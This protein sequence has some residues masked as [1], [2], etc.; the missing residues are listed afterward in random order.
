MLDAWGLQALAASGVAISGGSFLLLLAL[1][2]SVVGLKG[3][4]KRLVDDQGIVRRACIPKELLESSK[5]QAREC[6]DKKS[7]QTEKNVTQLEAALREAAGAIQR[8]DKEMKKMI[9]RIQELET[10]QG[11]SLKIADTSV[12]SAEKS[13]ERDPRLLKT[14]QMELSTEQDY[15]E[16]MGDRQKS[17]L[18]GAS[19][20][21]SV[22]LST[23]QIHHNREHSIKSVSQSNTPMGV[24]PPHTTAQKDK[25]EIAMSPL[26]SGSN[27]ADTSPVPGPASAAVSLR[28]SATHSPGECPD[29]GAA[30]PNYPEGARA[31][32][33][34]A[35]R[36]AR[37]GTDSYTSA[38]DGSIMF[39]GGPRTSGGSHGN[40]G[41]DTIAQDDMI[42]KAD[43]G[44]SNKNGPDGSAHQSFWAAMTDNINLHS[45]PLLSFGG[46][47][48]P[49]GTKRRAQ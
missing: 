48:D 1:Y 25:R 5:D 12:L 38:N 13:F 16:V 49:T 35:N 45:V 47:T 43:I 34:D 42:V 11:K 2:F 41:P 32:S 27:T 40:V 14:P 36:G 30:T 3:R 26:I 18:V 46:L 39:A 17:Y 24:L 23:A 4:L 9:D 31:S 20:S 19:V 8:H 29:S 10:P 33:G 6:K 7:Q 22:D 28:A 15:R 44:F 21:Q 37:Y